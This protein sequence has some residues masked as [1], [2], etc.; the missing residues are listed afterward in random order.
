VSS[1]L[2][3]FNVRLGRRNRE[4]GYGDGFILDEPSERASRNEPSVG[5]TVKPK[6]GASV[7]A[8][9]LLPL[10]KVLFSGPTSW[11]LQMWQRR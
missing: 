7:K 9:E 2:S 3:Y 5:T 10:S 1:K 8:Q 11:I 4:E 6:V